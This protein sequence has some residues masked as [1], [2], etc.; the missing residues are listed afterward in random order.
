MNLVG[1][2]MD[3]STN[4]L[5]L[6]STVLLAG[7]CALFEAPVVERIQPGITLPSSRKKRAKSRGK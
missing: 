6:I 1:A 7:V 3:A 5:A 2:I 4:R